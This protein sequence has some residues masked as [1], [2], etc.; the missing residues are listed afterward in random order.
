MAFFHQIDDIPSHRLQELRRRVREGSL[1]PDTELLSVLRDLLFAEPSR[2][3]VLTGP[4]DSG[5]TVT[6]M[7]VSHE[8]V[9]LSWLTW[10]GNAADLSTAEDLES[11]HRAS[12]NTVSVLI[13]EDCHHAG[14]GWELLDRIDRSKATTLLFTSRVLFPSEA[15]LSDFAASSLTEVSFPRPTALRSQIT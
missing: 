14:D 9:R 13:I 2:I 10:L 3:A 11:Q 1:S 6:S 5:K 7:M 8:A 4:R 12:T 15:I